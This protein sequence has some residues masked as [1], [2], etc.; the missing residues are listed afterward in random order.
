MPW[1]S[2]RMNDASKCLRQSSLKHILMPLKPE[3]RE[4]SKTTLRQSYPPNA[5]RM[6]P[7]RDA[8]NND[9]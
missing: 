7:V 3:S 5:K 6:F 1:Y 2:A 8:E 9:T 4:K